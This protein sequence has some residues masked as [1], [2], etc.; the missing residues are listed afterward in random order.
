VLDFAA[1]AEAYNTLVGV[2]AH[3]LGWVLQQAL[4]EVNVSRVALAMCWPR[5]GGS[6]GDL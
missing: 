6:T 5:K 4:Q 2:L 1:T 3:P